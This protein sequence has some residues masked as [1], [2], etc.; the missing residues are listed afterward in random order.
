MSTPPP[1]QADDG[2]SED[3]ITTYA[4]AITLLMAFFVMLA[5]L[6]QID[7]PAFEEAMPG[8][9]RNWARKRR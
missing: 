5:F 9:K 2:D 4:D 3:W 8:S 1:I 7:L 6:S